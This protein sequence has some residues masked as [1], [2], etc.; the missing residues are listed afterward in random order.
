VTVSVATSLDQVPDSHRDLLDAP[1]AT[2][3]TIGPDGRPQLSPVWFLVEDG[4]L[5]ISFNTTRQ[6]L[7]N[8]RARPQ[9][10]VLIL[11]LSAP[12]R[13]LE[14]RG[15]AEVAP[16]DGYEVADRVGAKYRADLRNYD[17]PG[18]SRMVV[19]VR[20]SKVNVVETGR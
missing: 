2:F 9:C 17:G 15:D 16:D 12:Y 6:K 5:R 14:I 10:T 13:Y 4:Q 8:L 19:T 18:V 11:D 7:R 3:A 20:P 1:I